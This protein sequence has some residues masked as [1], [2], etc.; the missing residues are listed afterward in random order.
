[1]E[2][3]ESPQLKSVVII[4]LP[5]SNNPSLGKK[6]TAFTFY[7]PFSR[8]PQSQ[9][10]QPQN[11]DVSFQSYPSNPQNLFSFRRLFNSAPI[12]F[13]TFFG[14]FLF[15]LFLY[16]SLYS[17]ETT[18][19]LLRLKNDN[20]GDNEP[21]S[22][23]FPLFPKH[24][25]VGQRDLKLKL[26]KI[27]DVKRRNFVASNSRVVAV[28]SSSTVFPISGNVFPDGYVKNCCFCLFD[29]IWIKEFFLLSDYR[30]MLIKSREL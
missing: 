12:K 15:A 8:Q 19:E 1:M 17:T 21:S 20:D 23:L 10:Q 4:S 27:V 9:Q 29:L 22:F 11:N 18:L 7:N 14:V 30:I 26:G 5:P 2:D 24:G 13:F 28:D 3:D 25:V 16:G 6:I